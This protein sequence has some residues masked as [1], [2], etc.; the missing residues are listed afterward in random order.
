MITATCH[1]NRAAGLTAEGELW[2]QVH[3]AP[4]LP[5]LDQ[6]LKRHELVAGRVQADPSLGRIPE[7]VA[8]HIVARLWWDEDPA[9]RINLV[10]LVDHGDLTRSQAWQRGRGWHVGDRG[11]RSR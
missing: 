4:E 7:V 1:L 8:A 10:Q 6:D 5:A 3:V 11:G 9:L 2:P